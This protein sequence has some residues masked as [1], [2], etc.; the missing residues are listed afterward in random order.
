MGKP[1]RLF[2]IPKGS[3]PRIFNTT[4]GHDLRA[5]H[6]TAY[7]EV[8]CVCHFFN[9]VMLGLHFH[10]SYLDAQTAPPSS[11]TWFGPPNVI[12]TLRSKKETKG[13]FPVRQREVCLALFIPVWFQV[14]V[15]D[16]PGIFEQSSL[17]QTDR[18]LFVDVA[19]LYEL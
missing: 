19:P 4:D 13:S 12:L 6:F 3:L 11:P 9:L 8:D 7:E 15:V 17:C 16:F 14:Q 2:C 1:I 10:V 5:D 18:L